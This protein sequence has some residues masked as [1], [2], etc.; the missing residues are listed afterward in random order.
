MEIPQLRTERLILRGHRR[1]D[2]PAFARMWAD[3]EVARFI[4]GAPLTDEEA[5]AKYM[6]ALGH[7]ALVGYGFWSVHEKNGGA[8]VGETGFLDVHR[9]IEPPL[10]GMPEMGWA[11]DRPA[12][13][14]GYATEA[15]RA[16]LAWGEGYFGKTRFCCIIAPDNAASLNVAAKTGFREAARTT[17]KGEPT[18]VLHRDP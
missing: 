6:R 7:W 2:Y 13:G 14:K 16:A 8:R 1:E 17:Y 18:I 12:Q 15:A 11:F 9:A 3:P 4:S 5:W 10:T